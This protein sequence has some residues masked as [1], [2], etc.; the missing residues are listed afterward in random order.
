MLTFTICALVTV[1]I[2]FGL[3]IA[4]HMFTDHTLL[5]QLV[6]IEAARQTATK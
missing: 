6:Q 5:H 3:N 2:W 1:G 4:Q